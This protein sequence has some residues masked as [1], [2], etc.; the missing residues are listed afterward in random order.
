[1]TMTEQLA[2]SAA[3][4]RMHALMS[5]LFPICRSITGNG[6]RRTLERLREIIPLVVHEIPSGTQVFDWTVPDEWNVNDA[7]VMDE[8]G[9]RIIDFRQNNL[10]LL[11]Y[12]IPFEGEMDLE[13]LKPHLYSRPDLPHAIPYL[14]SY[15]ERRWGFC[16]DDHT[17]R[18]IRPG[19]Y[20]V[21]V[22]TDLSPG[23]L[24]L[25]ELLIPGAEETEILL[26]ANVC[27]PSLANNELSGPVLLTYLA[28]WLLDSQP[29]RFTYRIV[30][31]PETIGALT[32]LSLNL[33]QMKAR[34]LAGYAITCVG[35]PGGFTYLSSRKGNALVD[36]VT[37]HMLRYGE[38]PY[39]IVG[40]DQRGSDER[41]YGAPGV[42]LPVGS[43]M[44]AKYW[45]YPQYHTSLDDLTF[46]TA[47]QLDASFQLYRRCLDALEYNRYYRVTTI[48]EPQLGIRGLY[49]TI[50]GR[51]ET[52]EEMS[53]VMALIGY[54]DGEHD[55]LAIADRHDRP[56]GRLARICELLLEA[57]VLDDVSDRRFNNIN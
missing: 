8:Q 54:C 35:G 16:V 38:E 11:G 26:S 42:D 1:M 47:E 25:A 2:T 31:V 55:L 52:A 39:R 29:R 57:G 10:H 49:P 50:G 41:Q 24:S 51:V 44:R 46:V 48:G 6:V 40:Y 17:L 12:S 27:H 13:D 3:G 23:A 5:E 19:R 9:Q 53:D 20:R 14:T 43:L 30:F 45:D 7:Y 4:P 33:E 32:Y 36:R 28:R 18:G 56:A 15:Y 37:T 22:D 34:T 21:K